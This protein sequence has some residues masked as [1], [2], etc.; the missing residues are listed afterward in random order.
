MPVSHSLIPMVFAVVVETSCKSFLI[1][2]IMSEELAFVLLQ[3]ARLFEARS[4]IQPANSTPES[5]QHLKGLLI[6]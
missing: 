1:S 5:R 2:L 3:S 6:L 4:A